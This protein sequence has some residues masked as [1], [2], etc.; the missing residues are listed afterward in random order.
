MDDT[1]IYHIN[2]LDE[3]NVNIDEL[4][5]ELEEYKSVTNGLNSQP[6]AIIDLTSVK[7][8]S[9]E[10][11]QFIAK[12]VDKIGIPATALIV[13]SRISRLIASFFIGINKPDFQ[14]EIFDDEQK[15]IEWLKGFIND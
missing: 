14:V 9:S 15:A 11:R 2:F 13:K 12:E 6:P 10:G 3:V 5:K 8:I 7:S 1:G 4:K